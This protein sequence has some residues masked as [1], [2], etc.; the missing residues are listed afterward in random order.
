[1][2][3]TDPPGGR[4]F[5]IPSS[6]TNPDAEQVTETG[7][8]HSHAAI[9]AREHHIPAVLGIPEATTKIADGTTITLD[10]TAGTVTTTAAPA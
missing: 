6:V 1:V 3:L 10:G 5:L 2:V 9:V 4:E 7:G 8:V